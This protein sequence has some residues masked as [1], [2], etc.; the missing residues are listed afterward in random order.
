METKQAAEQNN[1]I[2]YLLL[3]YYKMLRSKKIA[4]R[5]LVGPAIV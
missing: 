5:H 2:E 1:G 3:L 4:P